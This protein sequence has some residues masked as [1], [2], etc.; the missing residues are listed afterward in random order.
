[1]SENVKIEA[2]ESLIVH[3]ISKE[4]DNFYHCSMFD[5]ES[6]RSSSQTVG[7]LF[8][9]LEAAFPEIAKEAE[10]YYEAELPPFDEPVFIVGYGDALFSTFLSLRAF[11]DAVSVSRVISAEGDLRNNLFD[12][13]TW[14]EGY[15][16]ERGYWLIDVNVDSETELG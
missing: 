15:N 7:V 8:K 2:P 11:Y 6:L 14:C 5:S 13:S 1:M 3:D 12:L 16:A 10:E 4:L 9:K